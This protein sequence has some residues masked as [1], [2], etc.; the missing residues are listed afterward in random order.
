MGGSQIQ[1][2]GKKPTFLTHRL[3]E[4]VAGL[5]FE[6]IP[7]DC[8]RQAKDHLVHHLGLALRASDYPRARGAGLLA[9]RLSD[10]SGRHRIIGGRHR[11][12]MFEAVFAN[13]LLM[14]ED[15]MDDV[16]LGGTHPGV[17]VFPTVL[18]LSESRTVT[19][20]ELLTA[21]VV[22]YDVLV[23]L[24]RGSW[25]WGVSTPR[26]SG[27]VVGPLGVAAAA[28]RILGLDTDRTAH[29]LGLAANGAVGLIEGTPFARVLYPQIVRNG[30]MAAMLA[31][32]GFRSTP[33][34]LEGPYGLYK[35]YLGDLPEEVMTAMEGLG[36]DFGIRRAFR[37]RYPCSGLNAVPIEL[38]NDLIRTAGITVADVD[39]IRVTLP[40]ER[41]NREEDFDRNFR[42]YRDAPQ[43]RYITRSASPRFLLAAWLWDGELSPVRYREA[44]PDRFVD[45]LDRTSMQFESGMPLRSARLRVVTTGGEVHVREGHVPSPT[46]PI[47]YRRWLADHL[48]EAPS[49]AIEGLVASV[50]RLESLPDS[51]RLWDALDRLVAPTDMTQRITGGFHR[52]SGP[53]ASRRIAAYVTAARYR[54]FP[55]RVIER[56]KALLLD[57]KSVV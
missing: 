37:K 39:S 25:T 30:V 17:L 3:A 23:A 11:Q 20:R 16:A 52:E 1:G 57:R 40:E 21:V 22:G 31:A 19:G 33:S 56:A 7:S 32:D 46:P 13:S 18:A 28:A 34:I 14:G 29:A 50:E 10:G 9:G 6:A 26:R 38:M 15:M 43:R 41:R 48:P 51:S 42:R 54:D 2:S 55:P 27:C 36:V 8:L 12:G 5:G 4:H 45:L 24:A 44:L 35:T 53:T 49:S 47:D